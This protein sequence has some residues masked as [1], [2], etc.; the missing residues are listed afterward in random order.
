MVRHPEEMA[1]YTERSAGHIRISGGSN[2][3]KIPPDTT[4]LVDDHYV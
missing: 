4:F 3:D 2:G 1:G